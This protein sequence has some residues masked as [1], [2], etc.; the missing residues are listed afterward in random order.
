MLHDTFAKN[1]KRLTVK[2]LSGT[3]W[4]ARADAV[5]A[6]KNGYKEIIAVLRNIGSDTETKALTRVEANAIASQLDNWQTALHTVSWN[7]LLERF[8][9]TSK[10]LQ[11]SSIS[12]HTTVDLCQSLCKFL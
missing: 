9:T 12:L 7:I 8:N 4:S 5:A 6:V 1:K 11:S 3:R 10:Y 2:R